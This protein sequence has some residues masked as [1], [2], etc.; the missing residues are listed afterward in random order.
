LVEDN[1]MNQYV[2]KQFFKKWNNNVLVA[3]NGSEA[4]E[5]LKQHDNIDIV[6]MDLQMP[7]MSGFQAAEII[8]ADRGKIKNTSIPIIALS[9][10]AFMETKRK[11]LEAGM[12]D[13]VTKP[14]K[15]EELYHK[16][17]KYTRPETTSQ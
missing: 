14:F 13:F 6:L 11:V 2:A 1:A 3:N 4:I 10:D 9:A 8:R 12:N 7:E 15:P 16:I 5:F 17:I